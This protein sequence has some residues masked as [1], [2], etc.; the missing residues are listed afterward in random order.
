MIASPPEPS[1]AFPVSKSDPRECL[2][3]KEL[4]QPDY[5]NILH[6]KFCPQPPCRKASKADSQRRWLS[7]PENVNQFRGSENVQ[8]VREWRA[9]HPGYWK[10]GRKPAV[11]LQ[12]DCSAAPPTQT[13]DPKPVAAKISAPPLQ[14]VCPR[15]FHT[16]D[17][18]I[19]GLISHLIDSPLQDHIE[20]TTRRLVILGQG[21]LDLRS[22]MPVDNQTNHENQQTRPVSGT[23][24]PHSRAVQLDRST[25]GP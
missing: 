16:Q 15:H 3:C 19:V 21:I 18:L 17:P 2:H 5:R 9:R 6:Q 8:R 4:F 7:K 20:A 14:D 25:P 12:D 11:A 13:T 22:A 10:R 23:A 24:P 1:A